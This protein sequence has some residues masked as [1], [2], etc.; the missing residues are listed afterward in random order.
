MDLQ[1]WVKELNAEI[2]RLTK[3][4]DSILAGE[5]GVVSKMLAAPSAAPAPS[6]SGKRQMSDEAKARIRAAAKKRWAK[7]RA[8][9][10][11]KQ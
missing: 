1:Q 3:I 10:T 8:Q 7:V 9:K 11:A 6:Q 4:R 5:N 2:N